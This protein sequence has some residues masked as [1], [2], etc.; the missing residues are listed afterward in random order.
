MTRYRSSVCYCDASTRSRCERGANVD[1]DC[2]LNSEEEELMA[3]EEEAARLEE[4]GWCEVCGPFG[5]KARD[6]EFFVD[7]LDEEYRLVRGRNLCPS[8]Y[9][10]EEEKRG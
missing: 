3:A 7:E 5:G 9:K 1:L 4:P 6:L 2:P 8:C 10:K